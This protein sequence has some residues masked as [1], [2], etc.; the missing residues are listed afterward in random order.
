MWISSSGT[1]TL[2]WS[3]PNLLSSFCI[4]H[5]F[6]IIHTCVE[7]RLP[8]SLQMFLLNMA[9]LSQLGLREVNLPLLDE[10]VGIDQQGVEVNLLDGHQPLWGD[11]AA[12][13]TA[14]VFPEH[15]QL[16][17]DD[18]ALL[19][20]RVVALPLHVE[21]VVIDQQGAYVNLFV[22]LQG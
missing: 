6:E 20:F 2:T 8:F 4:L 21:L 16:V 10:L 9:N 1:S 22:G 14:D 5:V 18:N 17:L 12:I 13:L 11:W 3:L 7:S 19:G 15:G